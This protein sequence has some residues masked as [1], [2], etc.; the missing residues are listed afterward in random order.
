LQREEEKERDARVEPDLSDP[1]LNLYM[2][3][4]RYYKELIITGKLAPGARI[5]SIRRCAK[6]LQLSRTTVET[7][8]MLLAA[9]GYIVSRPQ[10]GYYVTEFFS[11]KDRGGR[12]PEAAKEDSARIRYDFASSRVDRDSFQ[13]DLWRRYIKSAL[14]QDERLLSYGEPQ[15][16]REL[17]EALCSYLER[18]RNVVCRPEQIVV[19]AGIQSLLHILCP[20]IRERER[21]AFYNFGFQQGRR[22]FEDFGFAAEDVRGARARGG[23]AKGS[24]CYVTPSQ[25]TVWGEVMPMAERIALIREAFEKDILLVEDDYNSEFCYYSRQ[26]PSLQG[27]AGGRNVVYL[28]TFSRLL[29]PSIRMSFMVLPAGLLPLYEERGRYYNQTASK[30]EQIA[31]CQFIRDG[32]LENQLRK[33]RKLYA[34]KAKRLREAIGA[35]FGD[36]ARICPG[37]AGFLVLVEIKSGR[38]ASGLARAAAAAGVAVRPVEREGA[39]PGLLLSCASVSADCY[40]EALTALYEAVFCGSPDGG[41]S[42]TL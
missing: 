12:E 10:S 19:G 20:M 38:S 4:Y 26:T 42:D 40:E 16:E 39:L 33:A 6:Q 35:I 22:I 24:V 3:V 8:Y 5:A 30:T 7:A 1:G 36:Q 18:R 32:R 28:G 41:F 13:F 15:G 11:D 2:R 17:R 23:L 25:M 31:L 37:E 9:E 29:L 34:A 21:A 14:R 27:L